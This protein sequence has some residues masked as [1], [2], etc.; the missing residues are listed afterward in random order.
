[1]KTFDNR[2]TMEEIL[3]SHDVVFKNAVCD[4]TYGLP[5]GN[6][7]LGL[8][9]WFSEDSLNININ[10]TDLFD[11]SA[12]GDFYYQREDETHAVVRNGAKLTIDFGK[13]VFEAIY[14]EDF[15]AR[16][17][18]YDATARINAKTPFSKTELSAFASEGAGCAVVTL[19][20]TDHDAQTLRA[21]LERWGSRTMAY[22]YM[23]YQKK[24]EI[25][26]SGAA[27]DMLGDIM[28]TSQE[29]ADIHF[30]VAA[31]VDTKEERRYEKSSS[32]SVDLSLGA[33]DTH[34]IR[35]Y[36]AVGRGKSKNEAE[37][38]A[39]TLVKNAY[40]KGE[41]ALFAEHKSAWEG[42]WSRSFVTLPECDDFIE[43]L[44]YLN[45][46]YGNSEMKGKYPPHFCNGI[47]G[48]N[49]DFVPWNLYFHYNTQHAFNSYGAANHPELLNTYFEYR[50]RGLDIAKRY[51]RQI[52]GTRGAFFTDITDMNGRMCVDD[53][54]LSKNCTCGAQMALMMYRHYRYTGDEE[55]FKTRALPF[56][57][58]IGLFYLDMLRL[59][60]D[61]KYHLTDTTAYEG[62]P[63]FDDSI[64]D[65]ATI[66]ALFPV[67]IE[68]SERG[69]ADE[70]RER[71]DRLVDFERVELDTDELED[72]R[73]V[74]GIGKGEL[75]RGKYVLGVGRITP[76]Y[77]SAFRS[78]KT[79]EGDNLDAVVTMK[80][81]E[82]ARKTFGTA[83][84]CENSYYGF[85]DV[86][87]SPIYPAGL[88]G[89]KNDG[90]ELYDLVYNTAKMHHGALAGDGDTTG[91]CM[92]WCMMPIY[93][94]RLGLAK[95]LS[96]QL[97]RTA[98]TWIVY[99]QGFG[100][101]SGIDRQRVKDRFASSERLQINTPYRAEA[102]NFDRAF[103]LDKPEYKSRLTLWNYRHFDLETLP[104]IATAVN[105]M[106]LQSYD[107]A[108]RLFAAC[109][110]DK[111]YAFTLRAEGACTVS[112]IYS[113]GEHSSFIKCDKDGTLRITFDNAKDVVNIE[114][115]GKKQTNICKNGDYYVIDVKSGDTLLF[116]TEG[117]DT[118]EFVRD[119]KKNE[120]EKRLYDAMLGSFSEI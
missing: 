115:N 19:K 34:E 76:G 108:L 60:D 16:L 5:I 64:T 12:E 23:R 82:V 13:P 71:L 41:A 89:I 36:I 91:M 77:E 27:A 95:D 10:H 96:E 119:Y 2:P 98:S 67:L 52:K 56:M 22:W 31:L 81:G 118:L 80:A 110:S 38:S 105:E 40:L 92:G 32:H 55:F 26:L 63:P 69:E 94:A 68:H 3:Q 66:R 111:N 37:S 106:L 104:I 93:L 53:R 117:A 70:Y 84:K 65:L 29:L 85:P 11:N 25:G 113:R 75:A 15:E 1:M 35:F 120:K 109:L 17:S 88:V 101:Y 47:W 14:L 44:W 33:S 59:G 28:V 54:E 61:G 100:V 46:Y 4:P 73:F 42:F 45:L 50:Y 83:E 24:P 99:P 107:G 7:S 62:S 90:E 87:L 6:G 43:N 72:G 78:I 116:E 79:A 97:K 48:F 9:L 74:H 20:T 103:F 30:S 49:R 112:A 102:V 51:A 21:R 18:L 86:E 114:I 57:R 39:V 8:L 58:E